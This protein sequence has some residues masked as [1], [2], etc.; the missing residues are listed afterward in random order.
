MGSTVAL[1]SKASCRARFRTYRRS[2]APAVRQARSA[3]IG[4]RALRH[5]DVARGTTVHVYWPLDEQGEID[6]RPLIAALRG[7]G[8]T[9]VLPV[10]TSFAPHRPTMEHRRYEGPDSLTTNRWG[11]REPQNTP[12][13]SPQALDAVIV[14]AVGAGRNGHRIGQGAGYYDAFLAAV[15]APRIGLVYD[16]CLLPRVPSASHDIRLTAIITERASFCI[17]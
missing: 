9:V 8:A 12:S 13:V 7:C 2:L 4:H 3:L 15:E 16:A 5:R 14:P 11:I 17:A 6:T 1:P 10:V